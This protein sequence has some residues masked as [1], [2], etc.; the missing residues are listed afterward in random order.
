MVCGSRTITCASVVV[1]GVGLGALAQHCG[2][3]CAYLGMTGVA[4]AGVAVFLTLWNV[5]AQA[6]DEL[7]DDREKSAKTDVK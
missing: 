5:K 7:N 4:V 3:R 6:Y 1:S 2:W